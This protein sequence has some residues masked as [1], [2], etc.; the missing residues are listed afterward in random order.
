MSFLEKLFSA[1][2]VTTDVKHTE[3]SP[4]SLILRQQRKNIMS[5]QCLFPQQHSATCCYDSSSTGILFSLFIFFLHCELS[6]TDA[7]RGPTVEM[8]KRLFEPREEPSTSS[9]R[10]HYIFGRGGNGEKQRRHSAPSAAHLFN[11]SAPAARLFTGE[12]TPRHP[13]PPPTRRQPFRSTRSRDHLT[14]LHSPLTVPLWTSGGGEIIVCR[15][16]CRLTGDTRWTE[17]EKQTSVP[18]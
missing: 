10:P 3:I 4:L 12:R 1:V 11:P 6:H 9:P 8:P 13:T 14:S 15:Q 2:F 7:E 16:R 5:R 17:R 18:T